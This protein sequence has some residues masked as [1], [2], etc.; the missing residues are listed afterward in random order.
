[1]EFVGSADGLVGLD[2]TSARIGFQ[3]ILSLVP[4]VLWWHLENL[5]VL[6]SFEKMVDILDL[7]L[8]IDSKKCI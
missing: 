5:E 7:S 4:V 1:M 6:I 3:E 2:A 8:V